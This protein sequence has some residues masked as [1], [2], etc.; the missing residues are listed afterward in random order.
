MWG[1]VRDVRSGKVPFV[2][3][4]GWVEVDGGQ[5]IPGLTYRVH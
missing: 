4:K 5:H 3:V 2:K 1:G